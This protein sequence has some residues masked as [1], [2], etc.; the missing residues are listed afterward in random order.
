MWVL[1]IEFL[2]PL[3]TLVNP[4][5][6]VNPA[7]SGQSHSLWPKDLLLHVTAQ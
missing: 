7:C 1:G 5:T 2:G 4:S 3:L 6:P